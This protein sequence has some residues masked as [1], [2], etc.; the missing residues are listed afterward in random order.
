MAVASPGLAF[1][2]ATSA[3]RAYFAFCEIMARLN[4][5][6]AWKA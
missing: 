2:S 3:R 5:N 6:L 1:A 4:R